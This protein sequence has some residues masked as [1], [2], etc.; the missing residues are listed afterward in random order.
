[1]ITFNDFHMGCWLLSFG[2]WCCVVDVVVDSFGVLAC[3]F[4]FVG[5]VFLGV[6]LLEFGFVWIGC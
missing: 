3:V 2:L 6:W 4:S 1:M 5:F